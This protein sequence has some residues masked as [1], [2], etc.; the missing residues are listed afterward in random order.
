M[1]MAQKAFAC[2][3]AIAVVALF[4]GCA[5]DEGPN[6]AGPA[7]LTPGGPATAVVQPADSG[8]KMVAREVSGTLGGR[9]DFTAMWG[10]AWW[11]F[12]SDSTCTGTVTH[13]GLS[14]LHTRHVPNLETGALDQGTFRIVAANGDEIR[15]TYEG[16]G[17]Y[18]P[19][20][21]DL[22]H[23][24]AAFVISGGT[25]RFEGATG[26]FTGMF[27]EILDDPTW[28]SAGVTWSLDGIVTH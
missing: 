5:T 11:Q 13:L 21:A 16:Q 26:S 17:A 3:A 23:G 9:F 20:R 19:E 22:V 1:A 15:G 7:A 12:Y 25:G 24:T 18:D 10:E 27:L 8:A 2:A 28:A 4:A 6:P 14:T